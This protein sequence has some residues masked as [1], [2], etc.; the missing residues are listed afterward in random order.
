LVPSAEFIG[1][2]GG[3]LTSFSL[4][5]QALQVFRTRSVRDLSLQF[6][7]L[8][9]SGLV[10]WLIYG[11]VLGLWSVVFWNTLTIGL[12]SALLYAKLRFR[13]RGASLAATPASQ[14]PQGVGTPNQP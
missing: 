13:G 14:G 10:L 5:P 7:V 11:L 2:T 12:M 1:L 6:M 3:A 8:N 4:V 9:T